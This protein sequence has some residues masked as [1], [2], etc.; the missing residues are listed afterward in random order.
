MDFGVYPPEINSGRMYAGPGSGPLLAAAQAWAGLADELYTAGGAYKSVVAGLTERLWT[1]P[2]SASMTS[3]AASYAEWLAA[4]AARAEETATQASAAAAAYE[5]AFA[6]TVPPPEIAANRALLAA[7]V[8]T[9]FF[10][11]NTPAIAATEAQYAAM[12]AQDAVA[13][14]TYAG[15]SAVAT[16]LTPLTVPRPTTSPGAA[17]DQAAAVTQALATPA[18]NAHDVRRPSSAHRGPRRPAKPRDAGPNA[19]LVDHSRH[20]GQSHRDLPQHAGRRRRTACRGPAGHRGG[21]GGSPV[22]HRQHS[23]RFSH[24]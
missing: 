11:Q 18:G 7:L 17:A 16:A 13:M 22:R 12:W 9:N 6:M 3:A 2:A 1:G 21:T 5:A 4:T 20:V 8:A 19:A 14:Y 10:G 24:R 15:S 23:E